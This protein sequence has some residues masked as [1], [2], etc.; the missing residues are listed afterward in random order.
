MA[1]LLH[2]AVGE[3]AG[4]LWAGRPSGS[5]ALA[6]SALSMLPDADVLAF[7]AGIPYGAPFG[8]RGASHS[9]A[10]ALACGLAVGLVGRR[11]RLGVLAAAV[12]ASHPLLDALTDG[13]LGVA[14]LW[15]LSDQRI[16]APWR[17]IPVAPIGAGFLSA[18]GL[19]VVLAELLPS[20]PLLAFG[21]WP[22]RPRRV[23]RSQKK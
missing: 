14:L 1:S 18:R 6:F 3:A 4:R 19:R 8:H 21:L 20:L 15:P 12:V 23:G 16:F 13:G 10:F 5:A 17:P 9:L 7:V 2:V 22:S 11:G